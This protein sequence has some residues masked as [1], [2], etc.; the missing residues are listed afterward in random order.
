MCSLLYASQAELK[1]W[2][3]THS[4]APDINLL[5]VGKSNTVVEATCNIHNLVI[6]IKVNFC[7][8]K[9]NSDRGIFE[10]KLPKHIPSPSEDLALC[11]KKASEK[12][13]AD[14]LS[15]WLVEI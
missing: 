7:R 3:E 4:L 2:I 8:I 6:L 9:C 12:I 10:T 5:S 13:S 15:Y 14:D 1:V 11:C